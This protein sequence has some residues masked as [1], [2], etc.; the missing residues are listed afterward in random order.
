MKNDRLLNAIGNINDSLIEE[1]LQIPVK[2]AKKQM[3]CS[4]KMQYSWF[5]RL[6][7]AACVCLVF[8]VPVLAIGQILSVKFMPEQHQWD[9]TTQGRFPMEAFS[10][11]A[12]RQA[13][14]LGTE[15]GIYSMNDKSEAEEFLGI[16]LPENTLLENANKVMINL[17]LTNGE[18][19]SGNT[20]T[21]LFNNNE[22]KLV[23]V[24]VQSRYLCY[25]TD[26][27]VSYQLVTELNPYEN[28]G[29]L[30]MEIK[31]E[32]QKQTMENYVTAAGRDCTIIY[33]DNGNHCTA[34]AYMDIEGILTEVVARDVETENISACIK[35]I[36]DAYQ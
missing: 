34:Y 18:Q 24:W 1:A 33:S 27:E 3:H 8:S 32:Y 19:V 29:G 36:M 14:A 17:E 35:Q 28:G 31:D 10:K 20:I 30:G 15:D 6:A 9:V 25:G 5:K 23:S 21:H 13:E 7:I 11:E 22:S 16:S 26:V 12:L 2:N 4:G